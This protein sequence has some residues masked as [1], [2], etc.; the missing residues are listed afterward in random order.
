MGR[1]LYKPHPDKDEYVIFSTIVD[2]VVSSVL[3]RHEYLAHGYDWLDEAAIAR[4]D[5]TGASWRDWREPMWDKDQLVSNLHDELPEQGW[6]KHRDLAD[7]T[8][9]QET[10]DLDLLRR[11]VTDAQDDE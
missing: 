3:T 6:V 5:E 11:L 1:S 8:R 7:F 9:A 4:A 10:N 2:N